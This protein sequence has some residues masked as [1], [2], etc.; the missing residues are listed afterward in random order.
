[1]VSNVLIIGFGS[2]GQRHAL[3]LK[4][5]GY[6]VFVLSQHTDFCEY[7]V[8]KDLQTALEQ[9]PDYVVVAN[10]TEKHYATL[11]LLGDF[12]YD[13]KIFVEKPL[14][15]SAELNIDKIKE[16]VQQIYVGYVLRSHPL[17]QKAK[18]WLNGQ[19][20][21]SINSYCGQYLPDW[22]PEKDYRKNYSAKKVGGG[23]VNDLSH[24]LDYLQFLAG[25]WN[26]VVALGGHITD[27]EIE[28]EDMVGCLMTTENCE[29][30]VCQLNYWDRNTQRFCVINAEKGTCTVDLVSNVL[31]INKSVSCWFQERNQMFTEMHKNILQCK[32]NLCRFSDAL[33][34]VRLVSAIKESYNKKL[35]IRKGK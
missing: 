33:D 27:L 3:V 4:Q 11:A 26:S 12:K 6:D 15:H 30:V 32:S 23:V 35:W 28:S 9:K 18:E 20:I 8:F 1:M 16:M 14:F 17:I 5:M 29:N 31:T 7:P 21:Y 2:I 24:E 13:G 34:V 19:K 10:E 22:R 25:T